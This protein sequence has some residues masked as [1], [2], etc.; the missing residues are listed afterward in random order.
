MQNV[1]NLAQDI[2]ESPSPSS[3]SC[4]LLVEE[5]NSGLVQTLFILI[6]YA[7]MRRIWKSLQALQYGWEMIIIYT[8][9]LIRGA[10][11]TMPAAAFA[12]HILFGLTLF[13]WKT[14]HRLRWPSFRL[15]LHFYIIVCDSIANDSLIS[16]F[17]IVMYEINGVIGRDNCKVSVSKHWMWLYTRMFASTYQANRRA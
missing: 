6:A 11:E 15:K 14:A 7:N 4:R 16:F 13:A 2:T 17:F 12:F 3:S 1:L 10:I 9:Y 8:A 5:G